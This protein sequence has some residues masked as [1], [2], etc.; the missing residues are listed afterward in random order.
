LR[1]GSRFELPEENGLSHF[2]EHMVFRG[3]KEHPSAHLLATAFEDLGG[4]LEASTAADHGTLGINVPTETL[5]AVFPLVAA[6]FTQPLLR[7]LEIERGVIRE[8]I[9]EDLGERGEMIDPPTLMRTLAFPD[10]ALGFPI[11]GPLKN[12]E[13]FSTEELFSHHKRTHVG[14]GAVVAV[15]GPVS[16][17]AV[18]KALENAFSQVAPGVGPSA[19]PPRAQHEPQ[20]RFVRHPGS[21][22]TSVSLGFRGPGYR[23]PQEASLEMLLRI[24][25]DGMATRLYHE[26]CDKRGLC[27]TASGTFEAY[28]ETGLVEL[29]ADAAHAR[30]AEVLTQMLKITEDLRTGLVTEAEFERAR[31][32]ARFQYQAYLSE[33]GATAEFFALAELT[34]T[35]PSPQARLDELL[36]VSRDDIRNAAEIVFRKEMRNVIA[37]GAASAARLETLALSAE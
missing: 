30:A 4:T 37:V 8:E 18:T 2:L 16:P 6:V 20:F 11:T 25:D 9:L 13:R 32:R 31:R 15:S 1:T 7:D 23:D 33:P 27:Y 34:Q 14:G 22:Q 12:I 24:I 10:N 29:S 21:S 26:L 19:P 17:E 28:A 36:S 5:E 3:T 35:A